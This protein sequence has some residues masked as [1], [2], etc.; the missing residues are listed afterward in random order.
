MLLVRRENSKIL[1][2]PTDLHYA[3]HPLLPLFHHS[4]FARV[5]LADITWSFAR[6]YKVLSRFRTA[7]RT[8]RV[9][10][11]ATLI[12]SGANA[13]FRVVIWLEFCA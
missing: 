8:T 6:G 3:F 12:I 7:E 10:K 4:R 5:L 11:R 13:I 1:R 2:F 9:L